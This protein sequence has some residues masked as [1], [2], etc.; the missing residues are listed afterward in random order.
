MTARLYH[1]LWRAG[2]LLALLTP[3]AAGAQRLP[4][5]ETALSAL[6]WVGQRCTQAQAAV[7]AAERLGLRSAQAPALRA[8]GLRE[9]L[10]RIVEDDSTQLVPR[11]SQ[12]LPQVQAAARL[13]KELA[14][15]DAL[16]TAMRPPL[17]EL[18]KV[19]DLGTLAEVL[20]R[21][22]G[23]V[24]AGSIRRRVRAG[25]QQQVEPMALRPVPT[26]M[27]PGTPAVLS[28]LA[29]LALSAAVREALARLDLTFCQP[30]DRTFV[31]GLC[32]ALERLPQTQSLG[33]LQAGIE[34]DLRALPLRA[35]AQSGQPPAT[36]TATWVGLHVLSRAL[37]GQAARANLS[38]LSDLECP[39]GLSCDAGV[40][41][42]ARE[43]GVVVRTLPTQA[44]LREVLAAGPARRR[45]FETAVELAFR[46][47][48]VS[49]ARQPS[50]I[51]A[52]RRAQLLRTTMST[53]AALERSD[54]QLPT[55][56]QVRPA[57][58]LILAYLAETTPADERTRRWLSLP[59]ALAQ[60]YDNRSPAQAAA[61][62]VQAV[63]DA[64]AV[65]PDRTAQA[66]ALAAAVLDA[67]SPQ[68]LAE[69]VLQSGLANEL[70]EKAVEQV[71]EKP[72]TRAAQFEEAPEA[73]PDAATRDSRPFIADYLTGL[74]AA[75]VFQHW[76]PQDIPNVNYNTTGLNLL[77]LEAIA[78]FEEF[79]ALRRLQGYL[80]Y[81]FAPG[82]KAR[83]DA[84]IELI[85]EETAGWQQFVAN[86]GVAL[87]FMSSQ[88]VERGPVV[89]F[90]QWFF[91][92]AAESLQDYWY[93]DA[94]TVA[95]LVPGDVVRTNTVMSTVTFGINST[96]LRPGGGQRW[97]WQAGGYYM[98]YRKPYTHERVTA[99][100]GAAIFNATFAGYG[101]YAEVARYFGAAGGQRPIALAAHAKLGPADVTLDDVSAEDVLPG[102]ASLWMLEM[103]ARLE[104]PLVWVGGF[105]FGGHT[106]AAYRTFGDF[107]SGDDPDPARVNDS[108]LNDD[109]IIGVSAQGGYFF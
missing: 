90:E 83:Q 46:E 68:R 99:V 35:L 61:L 100:D 5:P 8:A 15:S 77:R 25:L 37:D 106:Y 10:H 57:T 13:C 11:A 104:V 55:A 92:V 3:T 32:G 89:G 105:Y 98:H 58:E 101:G 59:S 88:L 72:D 81:E 41:A 102:D 23:S 22:A 27:P 73:R 71:A 29:Q 64:G 44:Q 7:E 97:G 49:L 103:R 28:R 84:L 107:F 80:R 16:E 62:V 94:S 31:D 21:P 2:L 78:N 36:V 30:P 14:A 56:E 18:R 43:A 38:A 19:G 48:M 86:L 52:A 1:H 63:T 34:R 6:D 109:L 26:S 67:D 93:Y 74:R 47:A 45:Y 96:S 75:W 87:P 76:T 54:G 82:G 4:R 79:P 95:L 69:L 50:D 108:S 65:L 66:L 51:A 39:A 24:S 33:E 17:E 60:A 91:L 40:L 85:E 70:I 53:L 9:A 20:G 42:M 12:W